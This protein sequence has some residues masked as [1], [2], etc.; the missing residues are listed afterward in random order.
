MEGIGGRGVESEGGL[1]VGGTV[2]GEQ[3]GGRDCSTDERSSFFCI[4]GYF[5]FSSDSET[6]FFVVIIIIIIILIEQSCIW[7]I[8][9]Q[10]INSLY[11]LIGIEWEESKLL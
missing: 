4:P 8:V 11:L 2:E 1:G 6:G 10:F 7:R 9:D 3:A 5:N